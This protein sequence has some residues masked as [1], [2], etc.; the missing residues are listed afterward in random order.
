MLRKEGIAYTT[1]TV[2]DVTLDGVID[3]KADIAAAE[4]RKPAEPRPTMYEKFGAEL[5]KQPTAKP[6]ETVPEEA[7]LDG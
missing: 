6:S 4:Q 1:L 7:L 2:G 3:T 5:L